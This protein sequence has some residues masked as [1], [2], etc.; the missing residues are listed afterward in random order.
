MNSVA[1]SRSGAGYW[2]DRASTYAT[3]GKGLAAVCSYGMPSFYNAGIDLCQRLA[4]EPWLRA[5]PGLDV[6]DIG[7]GVGRWSLHLAGQGARV[8][9]VDISAT[10]LEEARR[11]AAK[12]G[13]ADRCQFMTQDIAGLDTG[14]TYSLIVVVTVL[15]HIL[16]ADRLSEAVRRLA[17]HLRPGGKIVLLEAAP[18]QLISRCDTTIFRARQLQDYLEVFDSHGLQASAITGVDPMPLKTMFLPHYR[19]LP[20]VVAIAGLAAVT[21]CS[22]PIDVVWGRRWVKQSW[23]KL[24]VLKRIDGK[25]RE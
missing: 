13:L 3:K 10:M 11:R 14:S 17:A 21:L 25:R 20:K 16:E 12:A 2:D 9:G 5:E 4:L 19:K 18:N 22:L 7:C 15:Q 23:H 1:L 8:T 6:L 24:I